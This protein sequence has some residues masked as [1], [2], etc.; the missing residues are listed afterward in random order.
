MSVGIS[1]GWNCHTTTVGVQ[2]GLRD[3]KND[4]YMT[5]PF[6]IMLSNYEGVIQCLYDDFKDF[7]N[8]EYLKL[9][10]DPTSNNEL[11]IINTKYNFIHNHE[12]PSIIYSPYRMYITV[13][14]DKNY[15]ISNNFEKLIERLN[16]QVNNFRNYI[17]SGK[18][19]NFLITDFDINLTEL[20]TCIQTMYPGLS[21]SIV[22][23]DLERG[24][25]DYFNKHMKAM[26]VKRLCPIAKRYSVVTSIKRINRLL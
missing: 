21:Y 8:A 17:K 3:V 4:G 16:N 24:D 13:E 9:V 7:T 10:P 20:H 26:N 1:L 2:S 12:S 6:D 22:R 15:Y 5:C 18:H 19:I 14:D 23:F 11:T 25:A